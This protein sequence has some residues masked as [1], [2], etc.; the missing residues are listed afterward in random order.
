ME[1]AAKCN[2]VDLCTKYV[3]SRSDPWSQIVRAVQDSSECS[4]CQMVAQKVKDFC[5]DS[6]KR[7]EAINYAE[8][9]CERFFTEDECDEYVGE[10]LGV[11]CTVSGLI[12]RSML[13]Y[14]FLSFSTALIN[15]S[16]IIQKLTKILLLNDNI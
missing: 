2:K 16:I 3:W 5:S 8:N 6:D 13:R 12:D 9:L 4:E 1:T 11:S 15:V 14:K 7:T 10:T